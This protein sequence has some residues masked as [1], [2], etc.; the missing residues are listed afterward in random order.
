MK[1]W[2]DQMENAFENSRFLWRK[3]E[4]SDVTFTNDFIRYARI[5]LVGLE[6]WNKKISINLSKICSTVIVHDVFPADLPSR[7]SL[8]I[9]A[10]LQGNSNKLG[11]RGSVS[12]SWMNPFV[13]G[14]ALIIG[15]KQW[16]NIISIWWFSL[17]PSHRVEQCWKPNPPWIIQD[18]GV[19]TDDARLQTRLVLLL[20]CLIAENWRPFGWLRLS[21]D[22]RLVCIKNIIP[23][24]IVYLGVDGWRSAKFVKDEHWS[25]DER[26]EGSLRSSRPGEPLD[27]FAM[28]WSEKHGKRVCAVYALV[29]NRTRFLE[30]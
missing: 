10:C 2:I 22:T 23:I 21:Q 24:S 1:C 26:S 14:K 17:S 15:I 30:A 5:P 7:W 12:Y 9:E 4:S 20:E 29:T 8:S 27:F 18:C 11:K 25:R 28:L 16:K 19:N 13:K 3:Q 6:G